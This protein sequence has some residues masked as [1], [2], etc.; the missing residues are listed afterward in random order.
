[1]KL[2]IEQLNDFIVRNALIRFQLARSGYGNNRN[3]HSFSLV[4]QWPEKLATATVEQCAMFSV[5]AVVHL[6]TKSTKPEM[7]IYGRKYFK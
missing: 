3:S 5:L 2:K 4:K 1:M 6:A 7:L